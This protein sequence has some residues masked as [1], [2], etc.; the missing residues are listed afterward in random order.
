MTVKI[1]LKS[2][3]Y[4]FTTALIRWVTALKFQ[5]NTFN[6][7]RKHL[8]ENTWYMAISSSKMSENLTWKTGGWCS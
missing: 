6:K 8:V 5:L 7:N 1:Y 3:N 4:I 2:K